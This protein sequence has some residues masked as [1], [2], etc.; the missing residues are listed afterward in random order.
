MTASDGIA[1]ISIT[2]TD[3]THIIPI[4][5]HTIPTTITIM[6]RII[7]MSTQT[8]IP[9]TLCAWQVLIAFILCNLCYADAGTTATRYF[10]RTT[11]PTY[12]VTQWHTRRQEF[13]Y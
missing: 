9:F 13:I 11:P 6:P 4:T 2:V 10:P 1:N 12:S 7:R 3:I 8:S 5:I